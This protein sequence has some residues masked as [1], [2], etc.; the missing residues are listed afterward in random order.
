MTNGDKFKS[1]ITNEDLAYYLSMCDYCPNCPAHSICNDEELQRLD[2]EE[3][4]LYWLEQEVH[5]D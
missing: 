2:C 5:D 3:T 1:E 4:I